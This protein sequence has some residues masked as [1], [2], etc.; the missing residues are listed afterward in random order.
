MLFGV[1]VYLEIHVLQWEIIDRLN[2]N[3][4]AVEF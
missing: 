2:V 4:V 1:P 3:V